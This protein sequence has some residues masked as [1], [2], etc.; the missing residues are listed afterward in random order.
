MTTTKKFLP[1]ITA[2][3]L[4]LP[5]QFA[6]ADAP[7]TTPPASTIPNASVAPNGVCQTDQNCKDDT[8][9]DIEYDCYKSPT[10]NATGICTEDGDP[11]SGSTV[12][13]GGTTA[14][15][16]VTPGGTTAPGTVT[17][18]GTTVVSGVLENPL[19]ATDIPTL[20]N[21][22]LA[23]VRVIGGIFLTLML[24]VV[25]FMFVAARG[26]PEKVSQARA[27]LLWT[28]IGGLLLLGAQVLAG[29]IAATAQSL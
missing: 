29:V 6:H 15:G 16:T 13:P 28:A 11:P 19:N 23:Y 7:P 22:I 10:T 9:N 17:P 3:L 8:V 14:P 26:N 4:L 18:G 25:G 24:V 12:T 20:L 2:I 27:A 1:L 5:L 21:E